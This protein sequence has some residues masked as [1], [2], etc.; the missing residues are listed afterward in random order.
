M[1][2]WGNTIVKNEDRYIWFAVKSVVNYLDKILIW[3]TGSTDKTVEIIKLLQKDYPG[4]IEF[5]EIGSV[6]ADGLTRARQEMLEQTKS[7]WILLVDGDEIWWKKSI[8]EIIEI[9]NSNKKINTIVTPVINLIG[10]IYHFQ[11]EAAGQYK[12][13]GKKGHFNIRAVNRK[14]PGLHIKNTYPLEGFYNQNNILIQ[15][16]DG[17]VFQQYPILHFTHLNRSTLQEKESLLKKRKTRYEIGRSF[18]KDFQYPEVFGEKYPD[19]VKDPW[20][21]MKLGYKIRA[22]LETPLKKIKRRM[23]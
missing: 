22:S 23:T 2:I 6:D 11:E 13:K 21:R 16:T 10:D 9:I 17:I 3:D 8:E 4:K 14:I 18:P 1:I 12:I 15:E 5:K 7:D 20:K 19:T